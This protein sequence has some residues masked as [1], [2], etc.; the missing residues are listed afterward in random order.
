MGVQTEEFKEEEGEEH[1]RQ[2]AT[3]GGEKARRRGS[4]DQPW[5][6]NPV[7]TILQNA[8]M[9]DIRQ[10]SEGRRIMDAKGKSTLI[11]P[12]SK[13]ASLQWKE[14]HRQY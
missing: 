13:R 11:T 6:P 10:G 14:H 1:A 4:G 9:K 3:L 5:K 12:G 7:G 8:P 2:Q